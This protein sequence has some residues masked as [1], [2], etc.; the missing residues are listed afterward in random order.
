MAGAWASEAASSRS[1]AWNRARTP[2]GS[3][4]ARE[5]AGDDFVITIDANQGYTVAAGARAVPARSPTSTSAGSRS[6]AS[7]PTTGATCAM[8][9]RAVVS[10]CARGRASTRPAACRDLIEARRRSTSA[11][12]TRHGRVATRTGGAWRRLRGSTASSSA[13]HEEPQVARA[14]A[15]EPAARHLPRGLPSRPRPDLVEADREPPALEDG[16]FALPDGPGLG[17]EL[18]ADF[19]AHHRVD[20]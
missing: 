5:A 3:T 4:A 15:R 19:I 6:R 13:H 14:P 11:T 16:H 10:P 8:C 18:D 20:V 12:S 2:S 9:A 1:A 17:W 7:G